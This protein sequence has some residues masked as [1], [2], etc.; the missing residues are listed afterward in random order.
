MMVLSSKATASEIEQNEKKNLHNKMKQRYVD[1]LQPTVEKD[2]E[3]S[4]APT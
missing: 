1:R 3:S 4:R 2:I